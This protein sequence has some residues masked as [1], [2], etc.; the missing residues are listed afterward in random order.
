MKTMVNFHRTP[1]T[2]LYD[3]RVEVDFLNERPML[4]AWAR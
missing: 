3:Q 2:S 4:L 1:M